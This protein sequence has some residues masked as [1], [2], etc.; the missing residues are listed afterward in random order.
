MLRRTLILL[1]LVSLNVL[2][3]TCTRQPGTA[4]AESYPQTPEGVVQGLVDASHAKDETRFLT[5]FTSA[6]RKG[7]ESGEGFNVDQCFENVQIGKAEVLGSVAEVPTSLEKRGEKQDFRFSMRQ[8]EGQWR[9]YQISISADGMNVSLNFEKVGSMLESFGAALQEDMEKAFEDAARGGSAAELAR[10][11]KQFQAIQ[12]VTPAQFDA[13]WKNSRDFRGQTVAE[14]LEALAGYLGLSM[15]VGEHAERFAAKVQ[16]DVRD[17]SHMQALEVIA[18]EIDLYPEYPSSAGMGGRLVGAMTSAFVRG[19]TGADSALTVDGSAPPP[20]SSKPADDAVTFVAGKRSWPVTFAGPFRID[21]ADVTENVPHATGQISVALSA[22]GVDEGV[23]SLLADHREPTTFDA[24]VNDHGDS[25]RCRDDVRFMGGGQLTGVTYES[26]F[27]IDL[28]NLLRDVKSVT[29]V[30]GTQRLVIPTEIKP[31][32]FDRP[33]PGQKKKVGDL[34]LAV[35]MAAENTTINIS[36]PTETL[37]KLLVRFWAL[38]AAGNDI[39]IFHQD[40]AM[41]MRDRAQASVQTAKTPAKL[42]L[43]VITGHEEIEYPFEIRDIPLVHHAEMPDK[44]EELAFPGHSVPLEVQFRRHRSSY[45]F[46]D[47]RGGQPIQQGC[48]RRACEVSLPRCGGKGSRGLF[49]HADGRILGKG[50]RSRRD[51]RE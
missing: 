38:D 49:D 19:L 10:K 33:R 22:R 9:I 31:V 41:W 29:S 45:P 37:S 21:V 15:H 13:R 4:H 35:K 28:K 27:P 39:G 43:K 25:L 20:E 51:S 18:G 23:L 8:E 30:K 44:I 36:G 40:C 3:L 42:L 14:A 11:K 17:M 1:V 12:P 6:A 48:A 34:P 7:L 5:Y 32:E 16:T 2:P 47:A 26:V 50:S 46:R 24:V